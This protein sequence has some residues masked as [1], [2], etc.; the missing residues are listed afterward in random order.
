[1]RIHLTAL[2]CRLN[3]AELENWAEGFRDR[4]HSISNDFSDADL[5]VLNT[6]A[7]TNEAV[8][9]SRQLIR[10]SH[11]RNPMSKLVVTG[12]CASLDPE[13]KDK[14]TAIDLLVTNVEKDRLV[15]IVGN[16]LSAEAAP[17]ICADP[18]EMP[19]FLRGRNRAFIKIQDGCR[20]R[21]TYCIVTVARGPERSRDARDI[22]GQI[23][24]LSSRGVKEVVLTG[25]H[26]GGY[27]SDNNSNLYTLIKTILAETDIP[28]LRLA[29]VEPWDLHEDFFGLFENERLMPHMHLPLQSGNDEILKRMA[30]RCNTSNFARLV[31]Q[32][33]ISIPDFNVTTDVIVGFPGE[34]DK[35]WEQGLDFIRRM[36]FPHIHIFPYSPRDGTAAASMPEQIHP[37]TK[38]NRC[39]QL[40]DI[41]LD[42]KRKY[43]ERQPGKKYQVLFENLNPASGNGFYSGYTPNYLRVLIP[44]ADGGDGITNQIKQVTITGLTEESDGLTAEPST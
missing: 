15:D 14:I 13:L 37:D 36:G 32:A 39:K 9:K 1:M 25:V 31:E 40:H 35:R 11:R 8:K 17:N 20:H 18:G 44:R 12:C 4:G 10:R 23:C 27:G 7:V 38:R 6:C 26:V 28:R 41:A 34:T 33:R 29:S 16:H 5:I 43:L 30:R 42:L 24:R 2:G 21:C 3:E 19:L 22:I